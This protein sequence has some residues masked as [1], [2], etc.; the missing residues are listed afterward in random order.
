MTRTS[1]APDLARPARSLLLGF[2]VLS[3]VVFWYTLLEPF[4]SVKSTLTQLAA[5]ALLVLGV[6]AL[7]GRSLAWTRDRLREAFAGPVG[8]AV[9]FGVGSAVLST[10]CSIS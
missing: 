1:P 5:L 2:L 4:E 7:R 9:L 3:P 8:V 10:V 6:V